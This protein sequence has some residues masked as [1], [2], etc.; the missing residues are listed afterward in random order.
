LSEF[1][2]SFAFKNK[3][4]FAGLKDMYNFIRKQVPDSLKYY[5]EDTWER[6]CYYDNMIMEST[7]QCL[8]FQKYRLTG[9][10]HTIDLIVTGKPLSVSIDPYLTLI[11]RTPGDNIKKL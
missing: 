10:E 1:R 4:P 5:L 2:D 9:G 6:V 11:D 8:Y 3:P 7:V